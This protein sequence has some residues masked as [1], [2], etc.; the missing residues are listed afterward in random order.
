MGSTPNNNFF[1][2][3]FS[4]FYRRFRLLNPKKAQS[5]SPS[6]PGSGF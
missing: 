6:G 4:G 5:Q 3:I 2:S 1:L